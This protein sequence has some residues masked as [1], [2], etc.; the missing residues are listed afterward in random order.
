MSEHEK[1]KDKEKDGGAGA[2]L[3]IVTTLKTMMASLVALQEQMTGLHL[4]IEQ[5]NAR[6][7]DKLGEL[8]SM[9]ADNVRAMFDPQLD[10]L[11]ETVNRQ[12]S[13]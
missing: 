13:T 12:R 3:D 6:L 1:K 5:F 10:Q 8:S 11:R 2:D 7:D 4:S 9:V